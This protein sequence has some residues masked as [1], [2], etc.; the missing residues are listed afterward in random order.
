MAHV[1]RLTSH[2]CLTLEFPNESTITNTANSTNVTNSDRIVTNINV[3][4]ALTFPKMEVFVQEGVRFILTLHQQMPRQHQLVPG[5]NEI[6][7]NR[8]RD[9][10]YIIDYVPR[11]PGES[12]ETAKQR[13]N[14]HGPHGQ[15][16][17]QRWKHRKDHRYQPY[18][19][20][21]RRAL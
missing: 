8:G 7:A 6:I 9:R 18:G 16:F 1:H 3:D 12:R 15:L 14:K 20:Q 11:M 19:R 4:L 2:Y 5:W 10:H 21:G 17:S 13:A